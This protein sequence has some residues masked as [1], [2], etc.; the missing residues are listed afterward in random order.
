VGVDNLHLLK[1]GG[2]ALA[3]FNQN[4]K[5]PGFGSYGEKR[6]YFRQ[7][8]EQWRIVGEF[9]SETQKRPPAPKRPSISSLKEIGNFIYFWKKAWEEKDLAAY[10]ACYHPGFR[11]RGMDLEAWKQH[12]RRLN[13][14]YGSVEVGI[15][16]LKITQVS[17]LKAKV[18]F[19]QDYRADDYRDL[20]LKKMLLIKK[21][22][23]WQIQKE[24]WQATTG[25][26]R[27]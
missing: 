24:E 3:K 27:R 22:E 11:S 5:A 20:G 2:L 7:N 14:K 23:Q 17:R 8:S 1:Q 12:R 18:S 16:Q 15:S 19:V 26:R 9:F 25:R 10:A 6:L 21:G 4:Y 13:D